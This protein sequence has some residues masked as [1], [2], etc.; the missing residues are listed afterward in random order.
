MLLLGLFKLAHNEQI[1]I[2]NAYLML[3]AALL[4]FSYVETCVYT[5]PYM[6]VYESFVSSFAFALN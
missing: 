3:A 5:R 1:G 4:F 2:E 6:V